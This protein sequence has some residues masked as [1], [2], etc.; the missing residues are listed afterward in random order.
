MLQILPATPNT[1]KTKLTGGVTLIGSAHNIVVFTSIGQ[2]KRQKLS[3]SA[4]GGCG[5]A[6]FSVDSEPELAEIGQRLK[7][8]ALLLLYACSQ[9][10]RCFLIAHPPSIILES[11]AFR[12]GR[13]RVPK[14]G[15]LADPRNHFCID[16]NCTRKAVSLGPVA[17]YR[18]APALWWLC[19]TDPRRWHKDPSPEWHRAE[20]SNASTCIKISRYPVGRLRRLQL[21]TAF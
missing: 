2:Q 3:H 7:Y 4:S 9:H 11:V 13:Q 5:S 8:M 17:Q 14:S 1:L 21:Q 15:L 12:L 10:I 19:G 6:S 20:K 16:R 18:S